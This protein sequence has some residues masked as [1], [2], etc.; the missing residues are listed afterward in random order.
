MKTEAEELPPEEVE[1]S[2][3]APEIQAEASEDEPSIED[4]ALEAGWTPAEKW[5]GDP[6]KHVGPAEFMRRMAKSQKS[7]TGKLTE[8]EQALA[9]RESEFQLRLERLEKTAKA[10]TKRQVEQVEAHY[11]QKLEEAIEAGDKA[12]VK[13][14]LDERD[15]AIEKLE[16]EGPPVVTDQQFIENFKPMHASV[17]KTFWQEHAWVLED[18]DDNEAFGAVEEIIQD[19]VDKQTGGKRMPNAA[20]MANALEAAEKYLKRAHKGRY[21][22]DEDED[23]EEDE[24]APVKRKTKRVP[25]L[26]GGGRSGQRGLAGKLPPEAIKAAD[27]GVKDKLWAD[28]EEYAKIYFDE[29]G[30]EA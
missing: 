3:A 14:T 29:G 6:Q 17:Q 26:A 23:M 8:R 15:E 20:E 12:A 27:E 9:D 28:R 24:P 18:D 11:Q 2:E 4:I 21:E 10:A 25:V 19:E 7:L 16:D 30:V 22:T 1:D 5:K 13:R